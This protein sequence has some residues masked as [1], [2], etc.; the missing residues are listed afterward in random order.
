MNLQI[1]LFYNFLLKDHALQCYNFQSEQI[2][3][4]DLEFDWGKKSNKN[5]DQK[6]TF[7]IVSYLDFV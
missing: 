6:N 2:Q 5:L 7:F 4:M 1:I 3:N